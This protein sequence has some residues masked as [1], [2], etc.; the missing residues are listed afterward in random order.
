MQRK[1]FIFSIF[2][3]FLPSSIIC[4]GPKNFEQMYKVYL[5]VFF[6]Q[7]LVATTS[8][9]HVQCKECRATTLGQLIATAAFT[10]SFF[11]PLSFHK[12]QPPFQQQLQ[13]CTYTVF[14]AFENCRLKFTNFNG[15]Y[16][17]EKCTRFVGTLAV[18]LH[19]HM[20]LTLAAAMC[21]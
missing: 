5:F 18:L 20:C 1:N 12:M 7:F 16:L 15:S 17:D 11:I 8:N 6:L 10:G 2:F 4:T 3:S 9:C 14:F 19:T 13:R 21:V